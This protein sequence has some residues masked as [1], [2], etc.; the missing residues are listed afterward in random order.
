MK[1]GDFPMKNG[2]FPMKNGVSGRGLGS[3]WLQRVAHLA[4]A[5][6]ASQA[7][8]TALVGDGDVWRHR[9]GTCVENHRKTIGKWWFNGI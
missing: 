4:Q 6:A 3:R 9:K 7:V 8:G 1:N 5:A 2:D